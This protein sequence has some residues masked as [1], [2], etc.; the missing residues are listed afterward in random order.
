MENQE[1]SKNFRNANRQNDFRENMNRLSGNHQNRFW[2]RS[3]TVFIDL[4][5]GNCKSRAQNQTLKN[6]EKQTKNRRFA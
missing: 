5:S 1:N 6:L 3:G 2:T 4:Y